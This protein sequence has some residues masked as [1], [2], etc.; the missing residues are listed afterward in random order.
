MISIFKISLIDSTVHSAKKKLLQQL[1]LILFLSRSH[2]HILSPFAFDFLICQ[3]S[4]WVAR[5]NNF[6]IC[7]FANFCF[8]FVLSD[9][10]NETKR[11]AATV[12]ACVCRECVRVCVS[13]TTNALRNL[14]RLLLLRLC[15]LTTRGRGRQLNF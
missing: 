12:C 1:S 2:S 6:A 7:E 13:E 4:N 8:C 5:K 10:G 15:D 9:R 3:I 14:A 11:K